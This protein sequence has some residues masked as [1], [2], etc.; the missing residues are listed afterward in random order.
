MREKKKKWE[1]WSQNKIPRW[2]SGCLLIKGQLKNKTIWNPLEGEAGLAWGI[3]PT[4]PKHQM[5][6]SRHQAPYQPFTAG[7]QAWCIRHSFEFWRQSDL[8]SNPEPDTYQLCDS[9]QASHAF[10]A[11]AVPSTKWGGW[12]FIGG[13]EHRWDSPHKVLSEQ[14]GLNNPTSLYPVAF[15]V[16]ELRARL[17]SLQRPELH[18]FFSPVSY[19]KRFQTYR[20]VANCTVNTHTPIR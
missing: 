3:S 17:C 7:A 16:W 14:W 9:K 20:K 8:G 19:Y 12:Y 18:G 11:F 5:L 10:W 6:S 1:R 13:R 2:Q 15:P 4:F